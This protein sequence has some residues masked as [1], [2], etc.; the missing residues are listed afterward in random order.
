VRIGTEWGR[1]EVNGA[2]VH[3]SAP[4]NA[5]AVT[6]CDVAAGADRVMPAVRAEVAGIVDAERVGGAEDGGDLTFAGE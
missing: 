3:P 5:R 2:G 1:L 6:A 4:K